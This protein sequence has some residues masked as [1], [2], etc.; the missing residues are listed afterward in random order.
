MLYLWDDSLKVYSSTVQQNFVWWRQCCLSVLSNIV[1][2]SHMRLLRAWNV[3]TKQLNFKPDL[4]RMDL[5]INTHLGLKAFGGPG[6]P[7]IYKQLPLSPWYI[8]VLQRC[9]L[10]SCSTSHFS[11]LNSKSLIQLWPLSLDS[12][13]QLPTCR[14][15]SLDESQGLE[16]QHALSQT[17]SYL[18]PKPT[19]PVLPIFPQNTGLWAPYCLSLY[20][21]FLSQMLRFCQFGMR[22]SSIV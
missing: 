22:Q 8:A 12:Y 1:A 2:S 4:L 18:T 17:T 20:L 9:I 13:S 19:F 16:T 3:A 5:H 7:S 10:S 21:Y 6:P 11:T 15:A 14:H